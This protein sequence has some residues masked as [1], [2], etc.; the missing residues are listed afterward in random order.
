MWPATW[1]K[2]RTREWV[3][4]VL[5]FKHWMCLSSF[6]KAETW[7]WQWSSFDNSAGVTSWRMPEQEDG[8]NLDYWMIL[9]NIVTYLLWTTFYLWL[10]HQRETYSCFIWVTVFWGY[11]AYILIHLLLD[12]FIVIACYLTMMSWCNGKNIGFILSTASCTHK[13]VMP[14]TK[15]TILFFLFHPFWLLRT[16]QTYFI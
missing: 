6:L 7:M 3:F 8:K 1:T 9:W 2:F 5:A 11:L 16:L 4:W 13:E 15:G 12:C 10:W 14:L